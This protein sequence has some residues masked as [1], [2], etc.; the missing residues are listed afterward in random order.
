MIIIKDDYDDDDDYGDEDDADDDD[1]GDGD[2]DD[3]D[4]DDMHLLGNVSLA[5]CLALAIG[6]GQNKWSHIIFWVG[7][8]RQAPSAMCLLGGRALEAGRR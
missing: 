5:P 4:D 2:D 3:D 6:T 8:E 7:P 1:D